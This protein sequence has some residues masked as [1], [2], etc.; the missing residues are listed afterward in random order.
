MTLESS[1]IRYTQST[2]FWAATIVA[3]LVHWRN[4]RQTT[5]AGIGWWYALV[6]VGFTILNILIQIFTLPSSV[7]NVTGCNTTEFACF[8]RYFFLYLF[9]ADFVLRILSAHTLRNLRGKSWAQLRYLWSNWTVVDLLTILPIVSYSIPTDISLVCV[10]RLF[11]I[12]DLSSSREFKRGLAHINQALVCSSGVISTMGVLVLLLVLIMG[13]AMYFIEHTAQPDKFSSIPVA[14]W[15]ALVTV[16][17]LGYGDLVPK[18][19]LGR[20]FAQVFLVTGLSIIAI[21]AAKLAG[22]FARIIE[23]EETS[24]L[25]LMR[26]RKVSRAPIVEPHETQ[27]QL[28]DSIRTKVWKTIG[29]KHH[30]DVLTLAIEGTL[31]VL[32]LLTILGFVLD[33][34]PN[35]AE[36]KSAWSLIGRISLV[37][38][39][40]HFAILLWSCQVDDR[41]S[42]MRGVLRFALTPY[43]LV[44]LI[45]VA[46][47]ILYLVGFH[48]PLLHL[49]LMAHFVRLLRYETVEG[50]FVVILQALSRAAPTLAVI[51]YFSFSITCMLSLLLF[52]LEHSVQ[53]AHF[54]NLQ[55]SFYVSVV[56]IT[57]VGYGDLRPVTALGCLAVSISLVLSHVL[58]ALFVGVVGSQFLE[59][60]KEASINSEG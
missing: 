47:S 18:T 6:M 26:L 34:A 46:P 36:Y 60:S 35:L 45:V 4:Q 38:F 13:V 39:P 21:P 16:S 8:I 22:S 17:T 49:L 40:M 15:W 1:W 44:E 2:L 51:S 48:N 59:L 55:D 31:T 58:S 42:N 14:M 27:T 33:T 10:F 30:D 25:W 50:N 53:P 32:V 56:T 28:T 24:H 52:H 57:T 7:A 12:F 20:L 5:G 23:D 43:A 29:L 3:Q 11:R 37:V 19:G 9:L 41:Y 54:G